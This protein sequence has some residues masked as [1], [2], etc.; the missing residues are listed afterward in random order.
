[1]RPISKVCSL[2]YE[3]HPLLRPNEPRRGDQDL[4]ASSDPEVELHPPRRLADIPPHD[5]P[6]QYATEGKRPPVPLHIAL[7]RRRDLRVRGYIAQHRR[8]NDA[9]DLS[10]AQRP[11]ADNLPRGLKTQQRDRY[12]V[13]PHDVRVDRVQGPVHQPRLDNRRHGEDDGGLQ[14]KRRDERGAPQRA[15]VLRQPREEEAAEAETGDGGEGLG[16]GVGLGG[17]VAG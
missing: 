5:S 4:D 15:R 8:E 9:R 2:S 3:L 14:R 6:H 11:A 12:L 16:P 13:L 7:E 10:H 1:M 17:G